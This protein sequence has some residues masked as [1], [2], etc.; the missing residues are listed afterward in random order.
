MNKTKKLVIGKVIIVRVDDEIRYN[1][2]ED[3]T[4]KKL[5]ELKTKYSEVIND[6]I[7]SSKQDV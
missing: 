6:F 2:P 1:V 4:G 3:M 5:N 7:K